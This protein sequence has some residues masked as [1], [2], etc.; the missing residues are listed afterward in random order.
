M[1]A[2][3]ILSISDAWS[4]LPPFCPD[5]PVVPAEKIGLV[6]AVCARLW[7]ERCGRIPYRCSD[8]K[9]S[10]ALQVLRLTYKMRKTVSG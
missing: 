6:E 3:R 2:A 4:A 10:S 1:H 9:P 8:P 5:V 7:L